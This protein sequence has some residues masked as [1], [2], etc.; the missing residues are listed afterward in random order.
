M[1]G[2]LWTPG[3]AI[4][5]HAEANPEQVVVSCA[6]AEGGVAR[7]TRGDLDRWSSRLAHRLLEA[8]VQP[9]RYVAIA[10]PNGIEHIVATIACYKAG[11]TPMPVSSRLPPAERDALF[12]L[13][14]PAASFSDDAGRGGL[15][16]AAMAEEALTAWPDT[17]PAAGTPEPIKAVASGGSTG[18][19]KLIVTPGPFAYAPGGHPLAALLR[20]APTDLMYS[21]GPLYHNGPF[22][23]S[24]V[25]LFQG[26]RILLNER[27]RADGALALIERERPTVLNLVPTM[28]QRML[29]EPGFAEAELDSVRLLWHL[30]APCPD[31]AKRGFIERFGGERV[32]ELWAATEMNGLTVI[33]GNEW[34]AHPGSVGRPVATE[35]RIVD[36]QRRAL[37][38]GE[39]GEI[40]SRFAGGP[41]QYRYE[42]ATPLEEL[43][44]G[45][46]SV[47]DMGYLD[48]E[49]YLY[50]SDRRV[51]MI[52]SGGANVFPAE[53]ESVLSSHPKVQDVAVI[54]L[55]DA[56]LGRRVHAVV[57]PRDPADPPAVAELD[58]L[59][60]DRLAAY[61]VPRGYEVVA[62]LPRTEAGKIRRLG[63]REERDRAA[64]QPS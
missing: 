32:L 62:G 49:G 22:L 24:L 25:L 2:T 46:T 29:R 19:P 11:G 30:A 33:D 28:M 9:G 38:V 51:D 8:G 58:A 52:I 4:H 42:G 57:E 23:F 31:W 34:L 26:G 10:L 40:F 5:A 20:L 64:S 17:L 43:D 63:L 56:D 18:R 53:V 37:P 44:E 59:C 60:R 54:G 15:S 3:A 7:L 27:F 48:E 61:K 13:A 55:A 14:N 39:V 36:E 1:P 45:F 6:L 12:A 16:R 50:L 35:L 47:G 21:P 41:A